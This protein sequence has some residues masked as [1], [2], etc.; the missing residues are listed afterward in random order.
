MAISFKRSHHALPHSVAP[1]LQQ[2]APDSH[3]HW[4][5]LDTHRQVCVSLLWGHCSF[6]LDPMDKRFHLCPPEP[7]S[8]VLCRFWSSMLGLMVT[9]SKRA[10][11]TPRSVTPRAPAPVAGHCGYVPPQETFKHSKAGLA[12]SLWGL[13]VCTRFCLTLRTSLG[14]MGFDSKHD[15]AS[16]TILLE[17]VKQ[18]LARK[19]INISGISE[20]K[21]TGMG[22][23]N[24][25]DNYIYILTVGKSPLEE[26]E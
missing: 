11:A 9:S 5:L 18:E 16:P 1:T 26:M 4:R 20:L 12:L 17:V 15:F 6:L 24:S 14:G 13:L 25:N 21:W 3:L 2:V 22:K 10:Y 23:L 19:S 8:P 7:V